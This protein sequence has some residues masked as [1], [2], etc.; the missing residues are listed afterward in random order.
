MLCSQMGVPLLGPDPTPSSEGNAGDENTN[1]R[2]ETPNRGKFTC[3]A[4]NQERTHDKRQGQAPSQ[5]STNEDEST[6][7]E[8]PFSWP[9]RQKFV[10]PNIH[11]MCAAA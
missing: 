9:S 11:A 4:T 6:L 7:T 3:G 5:D 8:Q 10:I 2:E 1:H